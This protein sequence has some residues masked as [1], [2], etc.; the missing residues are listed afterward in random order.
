MTHTKLENRIVLKIS[1]ECLSGTGKTGHDSE[2]M[3]FVAGEINDARKTSPDIQ[4]AV[5]VGGGNMI[6]GSELVQSLGT[7][8]I[9]SDQAGMLSTVINAI[10][11][12][13]FLEHIHKIPT[14]VLSAVYAKEFVEP[15][16]RRRAMAHLKKNRVVIL[17]GGSGNPRFTTDSAAVLR[18]IEI[19][20]SRV[21]KGTKVDGVYDRDPNTEDGAEFIDKISYKDFIQHG[22]K[23]VDRTAVTLAGE[24][25]MPIR[26]FNIFEKGN[27]S[28][29]LSGE[30]IGSRIDPRD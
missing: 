8:P 7:T 1:G 11:L 27:R 5:V 30:K 22:L 29:I 2:A 4:L 6:R 20:A 9:V 18:A 3:H 24:N 10:L 28:K 13:D 14:R 25:D 26:I 16:I 23:I 12:Q 15:Y 17:S 21:I 19:E